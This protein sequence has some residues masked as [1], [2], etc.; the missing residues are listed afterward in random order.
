MVDNHQYILYISKHVLKGL[1]SI[2]GRKMRGPTSL[3]IG[4]KS[5]YTTNFN[6]KTLSHS[7]SPP[8]RKSR[9]KPLANKEKRFFKP[10][11]SLGNFESQVM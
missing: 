10:N 1:T 5:T 2:I 4:P 11:I 9:G 6:N 8:G 7:T 3:V